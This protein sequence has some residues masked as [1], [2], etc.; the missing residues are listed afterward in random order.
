M[1]GIFLLLFAFRAI[2]SLREAC[3]DQLHAKIEIPLHSS[4]GLNLFISLHNKCRFYVNVFSTVAIPGK[5]PSPD[6]RRR[7]H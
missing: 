5:Y 6:K 3:L 1:Y 4:V 7:P 2:S